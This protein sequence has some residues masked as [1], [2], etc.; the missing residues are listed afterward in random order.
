MSK[1][2]LQTPILKNRPVLKR[3][4]II[5]GLAVCLGCGALT[6]IRITS[7]QIPAKAAAL[8]LTTFRLNERITYNVSFGRSY[9]A[10]YAEI[11][12]ASRGTLGGKD[13]VELH[14]KIKTLN[15]TSAAF[16]SLDQSRVTFAAADTGLPL[17]VVRTS[18]DGVT[19]IE[20]IDNYLQAP[21]TNYDFLTMIYAARNA[22][23]SGTFN[24]QEG[25]KIYSVIFTPGAGE[26]VKTDAGEFETTV[27]GVQSEYFT[28]NGITDVKINFTSDDL[29][30]PALI[31]LKTA[32]GEFRAAVASIQMVE[33]EVEPTPAATPLPPVM[34]TPKPTP[35]PTPNIDNQPLLPELSFVLG[36]TLEYAISSGG[37]ALGGITLQAKE[38]KPNPAGQDGLLL[39]ATV[40]GST[41]QGINLFR[42]GDLVKTIV[43]PDTLSPQQIEVKFTGSLSSLNLNATFDQRTGAVIFGGTN[44]IEAPVGTHSLLSFLYA[45]R[46]FNLKPSKD[47]QNPVNDTR[48]AVFWDNRP[49]I[50][51]LR[52]S[53]AT[54]ITQRGD[55]VSAQTV[56]IN[57]GNPQL[58]QLGIKVWLSNE[59]D[60]LPLRFT[61]GP[62]QA[63]LVNTSI[64]RPQ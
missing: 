31:R 35:A 63:D 41:G 58:D 16:Y 64:V 15:L 14:S 21:A 29:R 22:G 20:T 28:Q 19:P 43:N 10:A 4:S 33:P 26:K 18:T 51:T 42:A 24:M 56:S 60:R 59:K 52:P 45:I 7:A 62:Y 12:V 38:R 40:T 55:K 2:A 53:E 3:L 17:Y 37:Q 61:A 13:A 44:R 25:E 32:K 6:S 8:P 36:E 57:T 47:A 23:G 46:S 39:T 1:S 5:F 49:Y 11:Y 34:P 30:L 50:F 27:S 9:N 48:V 54:L